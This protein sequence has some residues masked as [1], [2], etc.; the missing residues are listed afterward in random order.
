MRVPRACLLVRPWLFP[1]FISLAVLL[2]ACQLVTPAPEARLQLADTGSSQANRASSTSDDTS[3]Q[4]AT[5]AKGGAASTDAPLLTYTV[6][7]G[8]LRETLAMSGKVVPMRTA[9]LTL[10]GSGTVTIVHVQPGQNVQEGEPLVEFALDDESLQNARTQ[11]TLAELAY[12]SEQAKLDQMQAGADKAPLEQLDATIARDRA[13]LQK[14]ELERASS[15][16]VSQRNE[17]SKAVAREAA[18][19]RIELAQ[20]A[21]QA[22]EDSLADAQAAAQRAQDNVQLVQARTRTDQEQS[23]A[24]ASAAADAASAAARA[25]DRRVQEASTKLSQAQLLWA[26]TKANQ[27]IATLKL[28]VERDQGALKD[29]KEIEQAAK[30]RAEIVSATAATRAA[31]RD[32]AVD[33]LALDQAQSNLGAARLTDEGDMRNASIALDQAKDDLAQARANEQHAQERVARLSKQATSPLPSATTDQADPLIL[34]ARARDAQHKLETEKINLDE[35]QAARSALDSPDPRT[36]FASLSID[37]AKAQL[38]ADAARVAELQTGPAGDE[39]RREE[40]RVGLLKDQAAAAAAAAQPVVVLK[41]PFDA[42]V[43]DLGVTQGQTLVPQA[44]GVTSAVSAPEAMAGV[45]TD[46]RQVAVRLAGAGMTSIVA[47]AAETDVN[48]FTVGQP[49]NLSFPG[50]P[51][52]DANGTI[53][54][55]AAAPTVQGTTVTYPLRI[56]VPKAPPQLKVGMSVQLSAEVDAAR[57]VLVA[58]LDAIRSVGGQ[59]LV[60]RIDPSGITTDVPVTI[61]RM[62]D[63]K[64]EIVSG[65]KEGDVVAVYTQVTASV[66]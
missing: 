2:S 24:D 53:A 37:A 1:Q 13:E 52:Q 49:V 61:G 25:A 27:E 15:Q 18:D 35:A 22:A 58:P 34:E 21:V 16:S 55:I 56:D 41:A 59:A 26:T 45:T 65:V 5:A 33:Q 51:G 60:A 14:L 31:Q 62:A 9:Q 48:Q 40:T 6:Q 39:V 3:G 66:R 44:S 57:D 36:E 50:L 11:A 43:T 17:Q 30:T 8:T 10:R 29:A 20:V 54:E 32:L 28:R 64:A 4:A 63:M 38:E 7:R 42:T 12:E 19:R 46:G 47:N 23:L